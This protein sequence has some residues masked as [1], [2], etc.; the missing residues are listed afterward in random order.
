M[1]TGTVSTRER[2]GR[3]ILLVASTKWGRFFRLLLT[4]RDFVFISARRIELAVPG[5]GR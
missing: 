5:E 2:E 4:R 3:G 1:T